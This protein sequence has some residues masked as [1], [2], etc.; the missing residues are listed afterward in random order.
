MRIDIARLDEDGEEFVGA[1]PADI[2]EWGPDDDL[3]RPIAPVSYELSAERLGDEL[4]V[5]GHVST[6]FGGVCTRC[7]GPL[8]IEVRDD[9]F[10]VSVPVP[11]DTQEVDLTPELRESIL[12]A[13]PSHP[14]CRAECGGLCPRCGRRLA[15]GACACPAPPAHGWEALA[16]LKTPP[17]EPL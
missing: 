10:C 4:L 2:L 12:L 6:R 1:D 15:E 14:V 16:G 7:G 3:F 11:D 9:A 17:E 13:L 5:R 8:D